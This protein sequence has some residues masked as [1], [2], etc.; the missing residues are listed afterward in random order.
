MPVMNCSAS[1][2][3]ASAVVEAVRGGNTE[4]GGRLIEVGGAEYMVRGRGYARSAGD[5]E[6]IVLGLPSNAKFRPKAILS[7]FTHIPWPPSRLPGARAGRRPA[8]SPAE[9]SWAP[10]AG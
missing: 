5:F 10:A 6:N 7:H 2:D 1:V 9:P 3:S 8:R 4:T